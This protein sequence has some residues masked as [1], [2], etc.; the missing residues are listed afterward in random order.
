MSLPAKLA[1]VDHGPPDAPVGLGEVDHELRFVRANATLA[2]FGAC[3]DPVGRPLRTVLPDMAAAL[4]PAFRAVL[5]AGAPRLGVVEHVATSADARGWRASYYPVLGEGGVV[6][7][8]GMVVVVVTGVPTAPDDTLLTAFTTNPFPMALATLSGRFVAVNDAFLQA[9]GLRRDQVIGRRAIELDLWPVEEERLRFVHLLKTEGRVRRLETTRRGPDGRPGT[10]LTSA[11]YLVIGGR[12]YVL[13]VSV[14]ITA[15]RETEDALRQAREELERRAAERSERL[16][17]TDRALRE[18]IVERERAEAQLRRADRLATVGTLAAGIA[19]EINNP[20]ASILATAELARISRGSS[21]AGDEIDGLLVKIIAEARRGGRVVRGILQVARADASA[22][23]LHDVS[24]IARAAA[25]TLVAH[26]SVTA[27]LD[28]DLATG[29][30]AV[31]VSR[32]ALEQVVAN[33]LTNAIQA[34]AGRITIRTW[35][36]DGA[37]RLSIADDGCGIAPEHQ[38][39][40]FDPFFTTRGRDGGTGLGLSVAHGIVTQHD[41]TIGVQSTP[42]VGTTVTISLPAGRR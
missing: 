7:G 33:L 19:H 17:Q 10:A 25:E 6:V 20:L 34:G 39:H 16:E 11:D 8:V 30:P 27:R 36:C 5:A 41:G 40:V 13:S 23:A 18:Q 21:H 3:G 26:G 29:L 9:R 37:V 28:F 38:S 32:T 24:D 12:A 4:E 35:A 14:D 15:Q 42:G 1:V 2:G 31:L 22:R